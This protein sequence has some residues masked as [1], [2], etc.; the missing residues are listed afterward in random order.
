M[1][2]LKFKQLVACV[3]VAAGLLLPVTYAFADDDVTQAP[4]Q[5]ETQPESDHVPIILRAEGDA[6]FLNISL[7]NAGELIFN[8]I[9]H[10]SNHQT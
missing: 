4:D 9:N 8:D 7:F 5:V 6:N 1:K 2:K 10:Y 3:I